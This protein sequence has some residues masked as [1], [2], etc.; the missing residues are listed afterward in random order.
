MDPEVCINW[1]CV[2]VCPHAAIRMKVM[3]LLLSAAPAK[4]NHVSKIRRVSRHEIHLA[5]RAGG[6]YGVQPVRIELSSKEQKPGR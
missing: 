6:L 3:I 1:K 5:G 2:L 4:V